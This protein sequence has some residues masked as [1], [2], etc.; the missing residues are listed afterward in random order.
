M[1]RGDKAPATKEDIRLLMEQ[2]GRLYDAEAAWKQEILA[3]LDMR[4]CLT[5]DRLRGHLD[6]AMETMSHDVQGASRDEIQV[7]KDRILHLEQTV[8]LAAYSKS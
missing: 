4:L 3:A 1:L 5:E 8:G 6:A 2:I 7:I